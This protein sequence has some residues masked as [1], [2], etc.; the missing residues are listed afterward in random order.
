[1]ICR[2]L[3]PYS[4]FAACLLL[5]PYLLKAADTKVEWTD[6]GATFSAG[7]L[8]ESGQNLY[9]NPRGELETIRRYDLDGNGHLDLLFNSTHDIFNALPATVVGA[10][11]ATLQPS[12]LAVDG[13]SRVLTHDLNRDGFD[14]LVFMPNRQNVQQQRS[15]IIIAWGAADGWTT[16]RLTRQLPVNDVK[17]LAIGDLNADGWADLISVNGNGWLFG[18]PEGN[19]VRVYWGGKDGFLLSHYQDLGIPGAVEVA[20]G[21]FGGQRAFVAVVM[22]GEGKLHFLSHDAGSHRIT[23]S[24]TLELPL[25]STETTPVKA[26]AL[27][28][29]PGS[30]KGTD[31]IWVSTNGPSLLHVR[32]AGEGLTATSLNA[33]PATHLAFGR[34]DGDE[35]PDLVLTDLKPIY[36]SA[37]T[38]AGTSSSSV[39]ILWGG[40]A[41]VTP[42]NQTELS[43]P[44]AVSTA[45]GD[46][47]TDGHGDL[48]VAVYQGDRSLKASSLIFFGA[49]NRQLPTRGAVVATEGAQGVTVARVN[50][51]SKP[52]A[53]FANSQHRTLDDAV[54][55]RLYWGI[56]GGFSRDRFVD[57]PNLSGYKSSASDL[58]ADG[59]V[60][61]IVI[62]GG[63]ISEEAAARAPDTGINIYWGGS[64]GN[65]DS[66]GPTKFDFTRRDILPEK[67]LGSINVADLN[68][69]GHL[70]L[71][72]G[73]FESASHPDTDIVIYYGA[74]GGFAPEHRKTIPVP[75]RS[76]GCLIADYNQD[77]ELDIVIGSYTTNQVVTYWGKGGTYSSDRKSVLQYPAPID[78]EAADFNADGWL[79]LVVASYEDSVAHHHDTG[80][81]IFWGSAGGWHQSRSQWLPGMTPLG[82]AVADLDGDGHLDL[83]SPHYHGELS[84][85]QLP[86]YIFWGSTTG[87]AARNRT[88]LIVD[89]ASEVVIA[90]FNGD[91][92]PDLAFAAHSIDPGHLLESPIFFNDGNRFASP[93]TQFL[94]A[95]G[96]HYMWVQDIGNIAT[97]RPEEHFISRIHTWDTAQ[98]SGRISIDGTMPLQSRVGVEVRSAASTD[99]IKTS[100]WRLVEAGSF[101]LPGHDRA[102]QYRLT[103][104]S[105]NGDAYPIVRKVNVSLQ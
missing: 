61:M 105:E 37:K 34:L 81:S 32:T 98:R 24:H 49:G 28:V 59:H 55:L 26:Q 51:R 25:S 102:L 74:A 12:E 36:P 83:V 8:G 42:E 97:R 95:V 101:T 57:I 22:T 2:R 86:C 68:R 41:G 66:P 39:R 92:R 9:V 88:S 69:D 43:I 47:N 73:A 104:Q 100:T 5:L 71:V 90:D 29:H 72:L 4:A 48:L 67:H 70:D 58:N 38:P 17:S 40:S 19:I 94:P 54:P 23:P 15:S 84:R 30:G 21:N 80:S 93:K 27:L 18:Q 77:G 50:D 103:L 60:D 78:L 96:P 65:M 35:W 46:L 79:D 89:S 91:K 11:G 56:P 3:L 82:L 53:V 31:Q 75:G 52:V 64:K 44:N 7:T 33:A 6:S 13:S 16:Q 63:D 76:I 45:I 20:T 10:D 14:E 62:N 87:F 1:M 99:G 85:E